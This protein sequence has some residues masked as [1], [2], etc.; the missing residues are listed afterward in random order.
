MV[1]PVVLD[2]R[3]LIADFLP[4]ALVTGE[5]TP[6]DLI[7]SAP[8]AEW[9]SSSGPSRDGVGAWPNASA[10][11]KAEERPRSVRRIGELCKVHVADAEVGRDIRKPRNGESAR[12]PRLGEVLVH[13]QLLGGYGPES[14]AHESPGECQCGLSRPLN[15][16]RCGTQQVRDV[17]ATADR[18][19]KAEVMSGRHL[20]LCG[21]DAHLAIT[22]PTSHWS[23]RKWLEART[24]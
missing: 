24:G 14:S 2:Q 17:L 10:L 13:A 16:V 21:S 4:E 23:S 1:E 7:N 11:V 18:N 5:A 8:C 9:W 6:L 12:S 15:M 19:A 22:A 20:L 3:R